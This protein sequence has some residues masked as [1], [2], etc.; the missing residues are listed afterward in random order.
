MAGGDAT[1]DGK[2]R[3]PFGRQ[4][5]GTDAEAVHCRVVEAGIVDASHHRG[6]Q[7][8]TGGMGQRNRF[9]PDDRKQPLGKHVQ[10]V[11]KTKQ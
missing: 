3:W 8:T 9:R 4:V 5:G 6:S 7:N 10:G 1:C 2:L 11:V